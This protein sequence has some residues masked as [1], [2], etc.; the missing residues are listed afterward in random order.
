V[1]PGDLDHEVAQPP[2]VVGEVGDDRRAAGGALPMEVVDAGDADVGGGGGV[3]AWG[4]GPHEREPDRVSPQQ[5]Q[6]HFRLVHL[7]LEPEH[8][9]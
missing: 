7:D 8:V 6:A 5:H 2:G 3:D 9:A 4:R 1:A